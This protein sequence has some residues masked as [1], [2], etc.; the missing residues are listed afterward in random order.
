MHVAVWI[1]TLF[2]FLL[3]SISLRGCTFCLSISQSM[4]GG[5]FTGLGYYEWGCREHLRTTSLCVDSVTFIIRRQEKQKWRAKTD[6]QAVSGMHLLLPEWEL[7]HKWD[8]SFKIRREWS[9][10]LS[11]LW[12]WPGHSPRRTYWGNASCPLEPGCIPAV[13]P[14][15]QDTCDILSPPRYLFP[16]LKV[17]EFKCSKWRK[18]QL[19]LI[20]IPQMVCLGVALEKGCSPAGWVVE[21]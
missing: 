1:S 8:W 13:P 16:S 17:L 15:P 10:L 11:S 2:P 20:K 3:D 19:F 14:E 18:H 12:P 4:T 5:L 21:I 6:S 7:C 9:G